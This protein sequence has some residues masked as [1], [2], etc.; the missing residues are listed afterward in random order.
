MADT[1]EAVEEQTQAQSAEFSQVDNNGPSGLG[2][3]LDILLDMEVPI[4]VALGKTNIPIQEILQFGPGSV[5]KLD[6]PIDA[7]ADLYLKGIKFAT[8]NIVVVNDR[9]AVRIKEIIGAAPIQA[10]EP[11]K[12]E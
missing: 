11:A 7:P 12:E 6:K 1:A 10:E 2:A 5:I 4:T 9:F 8:G 3:S